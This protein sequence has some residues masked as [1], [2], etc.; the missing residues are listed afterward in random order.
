[1]TTHEELLRR[2]RELEAE[3]RH[4]KE[5]VSRQR[6]GLTWIDVPEDFDEE[7]REKL[8]ILEEVPERE[9]RHDDGK[10]THI[11]IEG[12]NYHALTCLNYTHRGKVDVI[13]IDPPYNTGKDGFTYR[14]KRVTDKFPNGTPIPVN[15]P[16]RHSAW[17]SF[18]NKRL[19]LAKDLLRDSGIIFISINDVELANLK[20]LCDAVFSEK[21]LVANIP[22]KGTGGR[23]DS[24][25]YAVVHE[26]VLAYAKDKSKFVA[27]RAPKEKGAFP[28]FD[29][30]KGL[31]YK[32]QLLR[33]WGDSARCEDRPNLYYP[34][35][36]DPDTGKFRLEAGN[37]DCQAFYP[38]LNATECGR[39]R[40]GKAT[41]ETAIE[42]GLIEARTVKGKQE[43]Y[44]RIYDA[45]T[46]ESKLYA[47]WLEDID[48]NTGGPLLH[49][50]LGRK[51]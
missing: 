11:L 13:Y 37:G 31:S 36:L 40:W 23:Q 45:R 18:M 16:L 47:T 33:K 17:L 26:Y 9:V 3:V 14:D 43:L 20:L 19:R 32:T 35:Y 48:N 5:Q 27:G 34:I 51:A 15:H 6:F 2:I 41:M 49:E 12:D 50:I 38:M 28:Y 10:P 42:Q 46:T 30:E 29:P 1:M 22:R 24:K 21:N 44:E 8:P 39:W 4:W 25:H 7:S